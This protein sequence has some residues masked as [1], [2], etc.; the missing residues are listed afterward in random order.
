MLAAAQS[1]LD[2][3]S[4]DKTQLCLSIAGMLV[5]EHDQLALHRRTQQRAAALALCAN[6]SL[7][8]NALPF[9]I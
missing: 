2:W 3:N 6:G 7:D 9:L 8:S 5:S 4:S 1:C